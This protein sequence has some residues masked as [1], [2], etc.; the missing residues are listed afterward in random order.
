MPE[1][2]YARGSWWWT[3]F[4]V[5][6][7]EYREP[8]RIPVR[9]KT[10]ERQAE[11]RA[12]ERKAAVVAEVRYGVAAP[13][14]WAAAVIGWHQEAVA[15]D[16]RDS[17]IKRYLVSIKQLKPMLDPL[18]VQEIDA[19]FIRKAVA[20]RRRHG[21][22][23]ATIRRDLTAIS[24]VL[25][26]AKRQ[27]WRTDNPAL[28]YDRA[29][30]KE[31]REPIALPI[32]DEIEAVRARCPARFGDMIAFAL[33]TGMR[34]EEIASLQHSRIDKARGV[35]MIY[36]AKGRRARAVPLSPDALAVIAK[37]PQYLG[38]DFV[39]WHGAGARFHNIA[40]NFGRAR[41]KAAQNA[42]HEKRAFVGFRFHDL[43]HMF[44]V[45]YLR[46]GG[47]IYALQ[48]ILGHST[49]KTTEGY[50]DYLTPA[51]VEAARLG[52]AQNTAQEQRFAPAETVATQ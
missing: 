52:L 7:S 33:A 8:L 26:H 1:N 19:A 31:R 51:E 9:G 14:T 29:S 34:E 15:A 5:A 4:T 2:C 32:A 42:A 18:D 44:A 20:V 12:A 28:D 43:R 41:R 36:K 40:S 3:R 45:E 27:G 11:K 38:S 24:Q 23:N 47:S 39:F 6:G 49:I 13:V 30:V 46:H 22:T 17:T 37:Q 21:A 16:L 50:L 35:A 48:Q 25:A 10:E